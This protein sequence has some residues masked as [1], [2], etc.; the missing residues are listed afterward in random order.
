MTTR[1]V[2][3]LVGLL[4][5]IASM[6]LAA[7]P[8]SPKP[9]EGTI[10]GVE[11]CPQEWCTNGAL[12]SGVYTGKVYGRHTSG[13]VLVQVSHEPLGAQTF[14]K[15]GS[16]IIRTKRGEFQGTIDSG[17]TITAN[18]S[19]ANTF[20]VAL[21]LKIT[22]GLTEGGSDKAAFSGFLDHNEFPPTITGD[23]VAIGP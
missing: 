15:G 21:T 13:V 10:A 5:L 11:V 8:P 6:S 14:V 3:L 12:F 17:G 2:S 16:W 22:E 4:C 1:R 9:V 20:T 19:P 23:L 7:A 18:S